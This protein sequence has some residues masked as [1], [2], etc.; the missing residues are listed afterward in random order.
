MALLGHAMKKESSTA[1]FDTIL[2]DYQNRVYNQAYRMLGNREDAEDAAQAVF[3]KIY[4]SLEAFRGESKLSTWIYRITANECI[5]R[6][7]KKQ[8][9]IIS[10]DEPIDEYGA[11]IADMI[12]AET[13]GSD[14]QI[15]REN[16]EKLVRDMVRKLPPE[17]AM[18]ISLRHF[19]DLSYDEIAA[20]TGIPKGTVATY[21]FRGR[22]KLAAMLLHAW[23]AA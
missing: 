1:Q 13:D 11:T 5:N 17:W 23:G 21:I 6:L 3:L 16:T 14:R 20:A 12:P 19:D 2:A 9:E 22:K 4:H 10:L 7:R 18:V 15:E 8:L